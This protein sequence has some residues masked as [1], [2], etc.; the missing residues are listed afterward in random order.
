MD[1]AELAADFWPVDESAD[2]INSFI[3]EQR[4]ADRTA[5]L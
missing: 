4:A 2:D 1:L 3:A 5:D